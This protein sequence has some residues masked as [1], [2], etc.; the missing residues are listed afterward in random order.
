MKKIIALLLAVMMVLSLAACGGGSTT[1]TTEATKAPTQAPT[2][3]ATAAPT[4]S[5]TGIPEVV[6]TRFEAEDAVMEG[7]FNPFGSGDENGLET[8]EGSSNGAHTGYFSTVGNTITWN[9]NADADAN[10]TLIFRMASCNNNADLALDGHVTVTVNGTALDLTGKVVAGDKT[11]ESTNYTYFQEVTFENVALVAGANTIVMEVVAAGDTGAETF[12]V[13]YVEVIGVGASAGEAGGEGGGAAATD[14][15]PALAEGEGVVTGTQNVVVIG[16]EWGPSVIKTIITLDQTVAASSVNGASFSIIELKEAFDWAGS[17][18]SAEDYT[19]EHITSFGEIPV[20]DAYTC[21]ENG[22]KV[23]TDSN[24]IAIEID[25]YYDVAT[26]SGI[27]A[28]FIYDVSTGL[29]TICNPYELWIYTTDSAALTTADGTAI[30]GINVTPAIDLQNAIYPQLEN[31]DLSGTYTGT[32]GITLTYGSYAP[33]EDDKQNALVIW[34]HGAGEGGVD[35]KVAILGNEVTAFYSEEF[36]SLFGGAYVL[37]PQSPTMWMDDGSGQYTSDGTSKYTATLMEL[38]DAYV[39][40]NPDIDTNRIIIGGCSNGG[41]MTMNMVMTYPDYFTAAYPVC[42]AYVDANITDDM[43][44]GIAD[45]P[46]W[47]VYALNDTTVDPNTNEIPTIARLKAINDDVHV[48]EFEDVYGETY[49]GHWSWLYVF[50][51]ECVDE[52]GT[53]LWVWMSEQSK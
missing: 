41:F 51:N 1:P 27:A 34:L 11:A 22:N 42:E 6:G 5:T 49:M 23:D 47:F 28:P 15:P 4:P 29:N 36:Q 37:T 13:D 40:A 39:K 20:K 19:G 32:D 24:M 2:T 18:G 21:D 33:A 17:S 31:V 3:E 9:I 48:S 10:V 16:E 52:N 12:N 8:N 43:L 7:N 26:S 46:I 38:I 30:T 50:N 53:N 35:N 45:L 14:A 25:Y 44:A